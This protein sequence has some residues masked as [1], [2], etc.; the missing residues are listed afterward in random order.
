MT[1]SWMLADLRKQAKAYLANQAPLWKLPVGDPESSKVEVETL[2]DVTG[3]RSEESGH[4][5]AVKK[6]K[7]DEMGLFE[8]A[9]KLGRKKRHQK[10]SII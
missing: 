3:C 1:C 10:I 6:Q 8:E 9:K 4:V 7:L 5:I 2:D